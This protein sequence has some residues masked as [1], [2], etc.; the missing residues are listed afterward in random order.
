M[1]ILKR[2]EILLKSISLN[3]LEEMVTNSFK[4]INYLILEEQ[5]NAINK[6]IIKMKNVAT[7][8]HDWYTYWHIIKNNEIMG[9]IGFKGINNGEA[10]VGY[11]ILEKYEGNGYVTKALNLI[12]DWAFSHENCKIITASKVL[13]NN[14]G[15][16]RVLEK[17]G[18]KK[19][20]EDDESFYYIRSKV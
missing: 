8:L 12:I 2:D 6:K 1:M 9:M 3:E 19:I 20:R 15:S 10:E 13:K 5:K 16:Q 11:G 17:N 14:H 7:E 18:F 4:N